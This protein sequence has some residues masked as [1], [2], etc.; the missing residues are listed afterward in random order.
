MACG[1]AR[2]FAG[3][4]PCVKNVRAPVHVRA[5]PVEGR[6]PFQRFY[7]DVLLDQAVEEDGQRREADV[8]QCQIGSVVQRLR[9]KE[10][11]R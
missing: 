6:V 3:P 7:G 5:P 8:V 10:K 4:R 2:G 11:D 9:D 1:T